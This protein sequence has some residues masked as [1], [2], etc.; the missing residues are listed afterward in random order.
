M[1]TATHDHPFNTIISHGVPKCI[2]CLTDQPTCGIVAETLGGVDNMAQGNS[3]C[4]CCVNA[5]RGDTYEFVAR[6]AEL[7]GKP[8]LAAI[9]RRRQRENERGHSLGCECCR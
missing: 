7:N 4:L 6:R 3:L 1:T 9:V 2:R 5:G 8:V